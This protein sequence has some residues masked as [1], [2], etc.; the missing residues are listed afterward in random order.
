MGHPASPVYLLIRVIT[1]LADYNGGTVRGQRFSES[2]D[3][4][5]PDTTIPKLREDWLIPVR[6]RMNAE[7]DRMGLVETGPHSHPNLSIS[8]LLEHLLAV[9]LDIPD[10]Q[11]VS[12]ENAEMLPRS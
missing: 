1:Y 7:L 12:P 9:G 11:S 3:Q 5:V 6:A 2:L 10:R 8:Q 4:T